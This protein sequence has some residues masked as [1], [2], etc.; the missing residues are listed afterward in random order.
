MVILISLS[1]KG[2]MIEQL[3]LLAYPH[4]FTRVAHEQLALHLLL[5]QVFNPTSHFY[6]FLCLV[7]HVFWESDF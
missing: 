3:R 7:S 2:G 1:L 4:R 6:R 5:M